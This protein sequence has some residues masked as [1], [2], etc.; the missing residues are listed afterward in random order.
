[1]FS[2]VLM[3]SF[4]CNHRTRS[5]KRWHEVE[6]WKRL[7]HIAQV[8][9]SVLFFSFTFQAHSVA[10]VGLSVELPHA[11]LFSYISQ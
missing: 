5:E 9:P 3:Y 11:C 6:A 4:V 1:M 2:K 7:K 10:H 8:V